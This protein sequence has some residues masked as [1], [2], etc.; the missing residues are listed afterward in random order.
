LVLYQNHINGIYK[1]T[2]DD[3]SKLGIDPSKINPQYIK[4]YGYGGGTLPQSND[5]IP[6]DDLLENSIAV[7]GENDMSFD[8]NDYILFYG[9]SQHKSLYNPLTQTFYHQ[10]NPYAD[11]TIYF[12]NFDIP[13]K[14]KR[15]TNI[16]L[17]NITPT[18]INT[19]NRR[20]PI[21]RNRQYNLIHLKRIIWRTID[22]LLHILQFL[23]PNIATN[24]L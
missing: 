4:L 11:T 22:I 23:F 17:Q 12:I 6:P 24:Y 21:S 16:P 20:M 10:K 19:D 7:I 8:K 5:S 15:I 3:I 9:Q 2:Y 1:I 18:D 14:G 13:V